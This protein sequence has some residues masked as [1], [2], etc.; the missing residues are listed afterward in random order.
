MGQCMFTLMQFQLCAIELLTAMPD[1]VLS[2][3]R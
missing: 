2:L 1:L 3:D